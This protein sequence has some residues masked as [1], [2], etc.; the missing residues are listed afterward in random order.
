MYVAHG[1]SFPLRNCR[2]MRPS[3]HPSRDLLCGF[4][5]NPTAE[6][7][8]CYSSLDLEWVTVFGVIVGVRVGVRVIVQ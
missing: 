6:N 3:L 4:S 5:V 1:M 8:T 7:M 2:V